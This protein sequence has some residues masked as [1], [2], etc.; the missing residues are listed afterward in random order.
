MEG[1]IEAL[2][3]IMGDHRTGKNRA[4]IS[5]SYTL[6]PAIRHS[7]RSTVSSPT[8]FLSMARFLWHCVLGTAL[9]LPYL[10]QEQ[11]IGGK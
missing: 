7:R 9:A 2:H 1:L 10:A 3:L 4:I 8:S 6:Y 5:C 11:F